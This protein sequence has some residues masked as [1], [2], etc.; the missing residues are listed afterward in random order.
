MAEGDPRYAVALYTRALRD[1]GQPLPRLRPGSCSRT[2]KLEQRRRGPPPPRHPPAAARRRR[3]R[4]PAPELALSRPSTEKRTRPGGERPGAAERVRALSPRAE[5]GPKGETRR[6]RRFRRA[7]QHVTRA[8]ILLLGPAALASHIPGLRRRAREGP[9][10][11]DGEH[12]PRLRQHWPDSPN[13]LLWC[14]CALVAADDPALLDEAIADLREAIRLRPDHPRSPRRPR[15]RSR[16]TKASSTK[17]S[18]PSRRPS[19]SAPISPK[20]TRTS[21][22]PSPGKVASPRPSRPAARRSAWIPRRR[23]PRQPRSRAHD[24][25]AA[26]TTPSP[27]TARRSA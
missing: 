19:A 4:P 7:L 11:H 6:P 12:L 8:A 20:L 22:L 5:G 1:G 2:S 13:A 15:R 9:G 16:S 17:P 23:G 27:P 26:S 25:R 18:P 10:R 24:R 21:A 3:G 14:A